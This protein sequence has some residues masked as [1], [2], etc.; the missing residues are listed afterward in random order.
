MY[1]WGFG[2]L[3]GVLKVTKDSMMYLKDIIITTIIIIITI[4]FSIIATFPSFLPPM[5]CSGRKRS[6][7]ATRQALR[8]GV[9]NILWWM[10]MSP[11]A[12]VVEV[13]AMKQRVYKGTRRTCVNLGYDLSTI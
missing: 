12:S 11:A 6:I 8:S 9:E 13:T 2:L 3:M 1:C 4:E 10:L 7:P 5:A